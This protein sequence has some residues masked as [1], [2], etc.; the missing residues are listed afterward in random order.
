MK[1]NLRTLLISATALTV[2][3]ACGGGS[4][5]DSSP[6]PQQPTAP[7]PPSPP[8]LTIA[9][10]A[11]VYEGTVD[12][13]DGTTVD[14][15]GLVAPDGEI[16]FISLEGEQLRGE[17]TV[18][19]D[20][21]TIDPFLSFFADVFD[22]GASILS[23]LSDSGTATASYEDGV[24]AGNSN[25]GGFESAFTITRSEADTNLPSGLSVINGNYVTGDFST[26]ISIDADGVVSGSDD[27]GCVYSGQVSTYEQ[28]INIYKLALIVENCGIENNEF[29]GL[30]TYF[31]AI[32]SDNFDSF[33][34]QADNGSL[35]I[36]SEL[37]KD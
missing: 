16:R 31:E 21:L 24:L 18:Q 36:T 8:A 14:I 25:F 19:G 29:S 4:S 23:E 34:F 10:T 30:A 27:D 2:L 17:M 26:A 33:L 11:G 12:R 37:L 7:Q 5:S 28:A 13:G 20:V 3:S 15:A 6:A 32:S 35:A 1:T 9:E 22:T